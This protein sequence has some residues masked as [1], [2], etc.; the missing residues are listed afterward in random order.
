MKTCKSII[1]VFLAVLLTH[2]LLAC[3][4]ETSVTK[5]VKSNRTRES[6]DVSAQNNSYAYARISTRIIPSTNGTFGYDILVNDKPLV[7][8]PHIPGLPGNNGFKTKERA[9]TVADFVVEKIRRNEMPPTV[10]FED[11]N[12]MGV[13]E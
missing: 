6:T 9:Q 11:L 10:T 3:V 4:P 2:L 5:S 1:P 13:L 8:Q 12:N 7:H